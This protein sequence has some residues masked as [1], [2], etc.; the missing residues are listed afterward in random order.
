MMGG[1][2]IE[3]SKSEKYLGDPIHEDGCA[4]SITATL[5]ARIPIAK[6]RGEIVINTIYNPALLGHRVAIAPVEQFE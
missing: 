5:D 4:A 6:E 3:N 1:M 2:I